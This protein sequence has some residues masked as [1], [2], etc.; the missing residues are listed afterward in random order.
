MGEDMNG[1]HPEN[2]RNSDP[3]T[4][5]LG[6]IGIQQSHLEALVEFLRDNDRP[7]GWTTGEIRDSALGLS[8]PN[9]WRR[10]SDGHRDGIIETVT[11]LFGNAVVRVDAET[12]RSQRAH[13]AVH[14]VQHIDWA[15]LYNSANFWEEQ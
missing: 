13:R 2:A 5:H 14:A 9:I 4:S 7:G 6:T 8:H 12:H 10:V 15:A 1:Y 3:V 11:D